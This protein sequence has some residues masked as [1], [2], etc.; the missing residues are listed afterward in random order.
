MTDVLSEA[1]RLDLYQRVTDEI[2]RAIE[3]GAGKFIMPW[4]G[5]ASGRP[6]NAYTGDAYRGINTLVLW[7]AA[8]NR[9]FVSY[10]WATYRQWNDLGAQVRKG[11]K[12]TMI[13]YYKK[14]PVK[15]EDANS[16]EPIEDYRLLA[17]AY[18]VFNAAQVDGW[19]EPG[20]SLQSAVAPHEVI[21]NFIAATGAD[22]RFGE[23]AAYWPARDCITVPHK[24]WFKGSDTSTATE[25][26]YSTMFHELIH[27]TGHWCRLARN[28]TTRFGTHDYA[29]EELIAELGAAYLCA[30]FFV[31]HIPRKDHAAYIGEWLEVLK[32][33]K[34]AIFTAATKAN[35]AVGWL[36]AN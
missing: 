28:L 15:A 1:T 30:E 36:L 26:Y 5:M 20:V 33:D 14:V 22:I 2:V 27:W 32:G 6:R 19:E 3:A 10:H 7:A 4:H 21:E 35:E 18:F 23:S 29:M 12:A 13:V 25:T 8:R 31:L 16:G 9:R 24:G 34:R 17:R 11:E